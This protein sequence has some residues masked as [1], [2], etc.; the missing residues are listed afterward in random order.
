[1]AAHHN[2]QS[3]ASRFVYYTLH[4]YSDLDFLSWMNTMKNW[5]NIIK[6]RHL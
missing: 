1:M 3:I 5:T 6:N 4:L 2:R